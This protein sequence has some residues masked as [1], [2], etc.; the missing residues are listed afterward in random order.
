MTRSNR[1]RRILVA[2]A[3]GL[4]TFGLYAISL[5]SGFVYDAQLQIEQDDYIHTPS[6]LLDVL[7]FRVMARDVLDFNR[8]V[9]LASLMLDSLIW[10]RNPFGYHLTNILLHTAN[11]LLLFALLREWTK[12]YLIACKAPRAELGALLAAGLGAAMFAVHPLCTEVVA[13][14][15]YR[16]DLLACFFMLIALALASRWT[17][18]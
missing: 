13:E 17:G 18:E 5:K 12:Q 11:V 8:P 14:P 9:H 6:N 1:Q 10:G 16:E 3:L 4:L 7:T 15:T 2:I